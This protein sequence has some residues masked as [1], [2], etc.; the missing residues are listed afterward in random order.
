MKAQQLYNGQWIAENNVIRPLNKKPIRFENFNT[1]GS[2]KTYT[3]ND[4]YHEFESFANQ[5]TYATDLNGIYQAEQLGEVVWQKGLPEG[6]INALQS[7]TKYHSKF[8]D[9]SKELNYNGLPTRQ[10]LT[11]KPMSKTLTP[12]AGLQVEDIKRITPKHPLHI[13]QK[14]LKSWVDYNP[15][16]GSMIFKRR[17]NRK[18]WWNDRY[19]GKECGWLRKTKYRAVYMK[20]KCVMVHRLAW[21]YMTGECP[22]IIDHINGNQADNSFINLRNCNSL[23]NGKNTK[24]PS[25]NTSGFIG[26]IK[27]KKS[28]RYHARIK[29]NGISKHLGSFETL[30]DAINCRVNFQLKNGFTER[31]GK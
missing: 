7:E 26:V 19:A 10:F 6:W 8:E 12:T 16:T 11:T 17:E 30:Q 13:T 3:L 29:I 27:S 31:H 9:W 1:D 14:E 25:H 2:F 4:E 21:L 20:G 5:H 18:G 24:L 23:I 28:G 22:E 15:A